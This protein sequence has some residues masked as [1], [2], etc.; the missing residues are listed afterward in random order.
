LNVATDQ[1]TVLNYFYNN[2]YPDATFEATVTPAAEPQRMSLLYT[3]RQG[4][5]QFVRDV[6]ISGFKTTDEAL[7]RERIRNLEPGDPLSQSSMIESQRRLYDLGI[8]A[9]VDTALQN[10]E[11]DTDHK[12]VLYRLE[13]ASRYSVTGG[14]GAQIA[15]IGRGSPTLTTPAGAAGFSPRVSFGVSRSN[16]MGLGHTVGFQG[17]LSNLQRRALVNYLA[18]QFKGNDSLNLTFTSLYDDPATSPRSI[19]GKWRPQF[20]SRSGLQ[21]PTRFNIVSAISATS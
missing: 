5:R 15:R 4:E 2:G 21:K 9:R 7:V 19:P 1:D 10:P 13:E 3:V 17:R 8:F 12:I 11:G 16:F 6:L 14:F 20:S 18:P